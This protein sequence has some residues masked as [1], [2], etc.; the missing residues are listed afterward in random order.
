LF[1]LEIEL[2]PDDWGNYPFQL[3]E[4]LVGKDDIALPSLGNEAAEEDDALAEDNQ[5]ELDSIEVKVA[6]K[7]RG[8]KRRISN[9]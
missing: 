3:V 2:V 1:D 6:K 4:K 5:E 8:I 9:D 7:L